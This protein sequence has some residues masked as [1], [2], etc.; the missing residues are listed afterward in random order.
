MTATHL[1]GRHAGC[2]LALILC[3]F[4][5]AQGQPLTALHCAADHVVARNGDRVELRAWASTAD[6]QPAELPAPVHWRS[7]AGQ[8]EAT[9]GGGIWTLP[10]VPKGA[11]LDMDAVL[12]VGVEPQRC[13]VDV[14]LNARLTPPTGH[15]PTRAALLP[16]RHFLQSGSDEPLGYGVYTY[17]LLASPPRDEERE[18]H[19]A[20]LVA[21]L[22]QL[23]EHG[24]LERYLS[25]G[26]LNLWLLPLRFV[27]QLPLNL[28]AAPDAA[29]GRAAQDL[30]AAYDY[31]R[32]KVIL[33]Q[34]GTRAV[35]SGPYL[36]TTRQPATQ[37]AQQ[38]VLM[39]DMSAVDARVAEEWLRWASRLAAPPRVWSDE[40]LSRLALALRSMVASAARSLPDA[41]ARSQQWVRYANP[42]QTGG[43][44]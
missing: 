10:T 28:R 2:S 17:F 30:L 41:G 34:T 22:R 14:I 44:R 8:I 31:G 36:L 13:R 21:Y 23:D 33:A 5:S 40:S 20:L 15:D 27:P 26:R 39:Q 25:P 16:A 29:L 9:P 43:Q 42:K 1:A 35:A 38:V 19:V 32:A 3:L 7:S 6:S 11:T 18:R 12:E 37:Q 4:S 24:E